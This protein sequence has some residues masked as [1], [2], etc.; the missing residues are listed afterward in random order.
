MT[1]RP[2]SPQQSLSRIFDRLNLP[3]CSCCALLSFLQMGASEIQIPEYG[4]QHR[5]PHLTGQRS[6]GRVAVSDAGGSNAASFRRMGTGSTEVDE[7]R[8]TE[9]FEFLDTKIAGTHRSMAF[10]CS[11][12]PTTVSVKLDCHQQ[13]T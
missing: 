3:L 7:A 2:L 5:A 6:Q 8:I 1:V 9:V 11:C 4:R 12:L 13:P 10:W